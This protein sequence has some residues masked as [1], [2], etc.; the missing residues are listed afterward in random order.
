LLTAA[1]GSVFSAAACD[2]KSQEQAQ[3]ETPQEKQTAGQANEELQQKQR[4][5]Y[6]GEE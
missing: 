3:E 4:A 2:G 6:Y 1:L 5:A